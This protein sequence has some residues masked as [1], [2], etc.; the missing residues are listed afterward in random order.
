MKDLEQFLEEIQPKKSK[1]T[2]APLTKDNRPKVVSNDLLSTFLEEFEEE[3]SSSKVTNDS[4][5]YY[6]EETMGKAAESMKQSFQ[7]SVN[8]YLSAV[9]ADT[10]EIE[11]DAREGANIRIL[12]RD[13]LQTVLNGGETGAANFSR[14]IHTSSEVS[15]GDKI[16]TKIDVLADGP[17]DEEEED[18]NTIKI[19]KKTS[20]DW[21]YIDLNKLKQI[22]TTRPEEIIAQ[23]AKLKKSGSNTIF[24]DLTMPAYHGLYYDEKENGFG[25]VSTC[26]AAAACIVWCYA[27]KGGYLQYP[28]PVNNAAKM[29]GFLL[30][31]PDEFVS[32]LLKSLEAA[33][34]KR[35]A[36]NKTI[37]MRW[38]DA[39]DFFSTGYLEM[40]FDVA[41]KTPDVL[42]YA[43][44][45]QARMIDSYREKGLIPEN[46]VFNKSVGGKFDKEIR[47]EDKYADVIPKDFFDDIEVLYNPDS[48]EKTKE[49]LV[50]SWKDL[51][52]DEDLVN[53]FADKVDLE[54]TSEN[55]K[56]LGKKKSQFK[57]LILNFMEPKG[58]DNI[59]NK[60]STRL[61][62][63][64]NFTDESVETLK[65]R[66]S[67]RLGIERDTILS[68]PEM[69]EMLDDEEFLSKDNYWNVLVWFGHGDD[70]ATRKE[71]RGTLLLIH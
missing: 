41:R 43:Y 21:F 7:S 16:A 62:M 67:E 69:M 49:K 5:D 29:V 46:F 53:R 51:G 55:L 25:L 59:S 26:P 3:M 48:I 66:V 68:Y 15:K 27:A 34:N 38:H 31:H 12:S 22:F 8:D 58:I 45:K 14:L 42:H 64:K 19:Q 61:V 54:E 23:N 70:A 63:Q 18:P 47:P 56:A 35:G 24:Y 10:S 6:G 28:G 2:F 52:L 50:K 30:N 9:G 20:G 44:T 60:I 65:D 33:K 1:Y 32:T 37:I 39:G 17:D 36:K 57:K 11:E 40:A 13:Q 4:A 71:V